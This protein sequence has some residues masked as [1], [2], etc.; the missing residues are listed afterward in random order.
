MTG[1]GKI[2]V[3]YQLPL[4]CVWQME[5]S[6]ASDYFLNN[7]KQLKFPGG[8]CSHEHKVKSEVFMTQPGEHTWTICYDSP[9][10]PNAVLAGGGYDYFSSV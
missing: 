3:Y 7:R 1:C 6:V 4:E 10:F 8:S 2:V 5:A 9:Q